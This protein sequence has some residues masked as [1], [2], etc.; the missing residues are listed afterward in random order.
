[1]FKKIDEINSN[2]KTVD[3]L[4]GGPSLSFVRETPKI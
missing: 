3:Q 2:D 1:M 4:T